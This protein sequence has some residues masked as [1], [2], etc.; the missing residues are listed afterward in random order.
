VR[1]RTRRQ[2]T[3]IFKTPG[4][5][6]TVRPELRHSTDT[7][8]PES[9]SRIV[10]LTTYCFCVRS[11]AIPNIDGSQGNIFDEIPPQMF[12]IQ[13]PRFTCHGPERGQNYGKSLLLILDQY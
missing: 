2:D 5:P 8:L 9:D 4:R 12:A 10:Y 13:I 11:N 6:N 3:R 1:D 7:S